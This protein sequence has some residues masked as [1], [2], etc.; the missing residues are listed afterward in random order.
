MKCR[1]GCGKEIKDGYYCK[2]CLD[3][4]QDEL[5]DKWHGKDCPDC[6]GNKELWAMT[7]ETKDKFAKLV[8]CP[9]CHGDRLK[10]REYKGD[11]YVLQRM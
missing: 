2:G 8:P 7:A 10:H 9:V 3:E 6:G 5:I 4:M 1:H 11:H